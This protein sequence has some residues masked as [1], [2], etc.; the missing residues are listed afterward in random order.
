MIMALSIIALTGTVGN[1]QQ[2]IDTAFVVDAANQN[3]QATGLPVLAGDKVYLFGFGACFINPTRH[4]ACVGGPGNAGSEYMPYNEPA[5]GLGQGLVARIGNSDPFGIGCVMYR[6]SD[7]GELVL[8]YNDWG[9][10]NSGSLIVGVI[11][12]RG[13]GVAEDDGGSRPDRSPSG[14][15]G[16]PN[17][18]SRYTRISYSLP[19]R[20]SVSVKVIDCNGSVVKMLEAGTRAAGAYTLRWDGSDA[21]GRPVAKGTYFAVVSAGDAELSRKMVKLE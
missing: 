4:V 5:P 7:E 13:L 8:G 15:T 20:M 10:D 18:F 1:A 21:T 9:G 14:P 11:V 16:Q 19:E 3:W 17:P 12:L 2:V 6:G